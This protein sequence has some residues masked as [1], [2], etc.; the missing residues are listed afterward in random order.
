MV[1]DDEVAVGVASDRD[2]LGREA[3]AEER[4]IADREQTIAIRDRGGIA[5]ASSCFA[6]PSDL[7]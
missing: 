7:R 3:M 1:S 5:L 6:M 2:L 4:G